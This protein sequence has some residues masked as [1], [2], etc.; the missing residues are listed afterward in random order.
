MSRISSYASNITLINQML[1]TQDRLYD[2]EAQVSTEKR[3]QDYLGISINSQRLVNLENTKAQLQRFIDNNN[4][5][6]VRLNIQSTV[7]AGID[8]VVSEFQT[9]LNNYATSNVKNE[10][11]VEEI[12]AAA[13]RGLISMQNLLNTDVAGRFIFAGS[14]VAN[15]PVE[16]GITSISAF[17][18]KYDG[19]NV[20]IPT[21][22]DAVLENFSFSQD[23]NNL[24]TQFVDPS[25]FLTFAQDADGVTTTGG[26]S[27]ITATSAL[28]SNLTAGATI[29][30]TNTAS[31]N[32]TYT[33]SSV[34]NSGRTVEIVTTM[35]TDEAN[36][37]NTSI[38]YRDPNK[39]SNELSLQGASYGGLSFTRSTNT[40]TA[41]NAGGLTGI[42]VGSRIT[43]AGT[44]L[45]NGTYTVASNDGTNITVESNKLTD[46]GLGAGN[47]FFDFHTGTQ[48]VFT[49][50]GGANDDTIA[51]QQNGGGG[52]V[53]DVFNGLAVGD[54]VTIANTGSNNTTYTINAISAD[55]STITVDE[56]V[57]NE[58]DFNAT[59]SGSNSFAYTVGTQIDFNAATDTIEI[60]DSGGAAVAGAFSQLKVGQQFTVSGVTTNNGTFTIA[61][62]AANGSS[63]TVTQDIT[64]NETDNDGARIR[65]F[66]AAGTIKA[67][68]Y[69][70]GD[71]VAS[72]HRA[73]DLRSYEND[74]TAIDPAFEK[75]IRGMML[76]LQGEYGT[77]GGLDENTDRIGQ[78]KYLIEASLEFTVSGTPPF[79]TEVEGS[80][81]QVRQEIGFNQVLL[82]TQNKLHTDFIGFLD[83]SIADIENVNPLEAITRLLDDSRALE[84]SYQTFAR[85]RQ[86]SLTNFL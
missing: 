86:L 31:N 66:A 51:V 5:E 53:P 18:Q 28:F 56:T 65:S 81:E 19:Y 60:Q 70:S 38:S 63:V 4:Q 76:I 33:V 68:P 64:V 85:I 16:L 17:Q 74:L 34:T 80:I 82:D 73:S 44:T 27:S 13:Y 6:E 11:K 50:N 84:A 45:N 32:G 29:E 72:T 8:D 20:K 79:G 39:T 2:L 58:T 67:T 75:A 22:R 1:R 35:L 43:V 41:A 23:E 54:T 12:Q 52:A 3:S 48:V 57:T 59:F 7:V 46:E 42:P 36:V 10:Q 9:A 77:S 37:A 55:G 14:R 83:T 40:L 62:I 69:Y 61:S 71:S 24:T 26:N 21:T 78:A 30:I 49:A 25:N 47:T 15:E